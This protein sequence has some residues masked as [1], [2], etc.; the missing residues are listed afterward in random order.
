MSVNTTTLLSLEQLFNQAINDDLEF[1]TTTNITTDNSVI[2]TTLKNYDGGADDYFN[3]WWVYITEGNN[4]GVNRY[5]SDYAN[6]TGTLTVRGDALAA[7]TAAVTCRLSRYNRD[8]KIQ[9]LVRACEEVYSDFH[10]DLDEQTLVT[11][12]ILPDSHFEIWPSSSTMTWYTA[13]TGGTGT[14]ARTSAASSTRGGTYSAKF[15]AS[16]ANDYFE[17][18]SEDY[19]RL[20][21]LQGRTLDFYVQAMPETANDALIEIYTVDTAGSTQTLTSTTAN[22]TTVFTELKLEN[23]TLNDDLD[24]VSIR[25]KVTTNGKYVIFDDAWLGDGKLYEY[26][27][28]DDFVE[29]HLSRVHLQTYG[30]SDECFYDLQPF[31]RSPGRVIPHEIISDGTNL[32]LKLLEPVPIERRLRLI[33]IKPLETLSADTDTITLKAEKIPALI[34]KARMIFWAREGEPVSSEDKSRFIDS[35]ARAERDYY[36]LISKHRMPTPYEVVK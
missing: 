3:D 8:R 20:L 24:Y 18:D 34:A 29:G 16:A 17:V 12:N 1:D 2:S 11:G 14:L 26:L 19:P 36:R 35:Y 7:E 33:G 21:D 32:Y 5:I 15:T 25:F 27:L 23:Q 4:E 10:L 31:A 9:A 22:G 13:N 6:A 30:T 28:P